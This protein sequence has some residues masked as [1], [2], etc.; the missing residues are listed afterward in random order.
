[1]AELVD[2]VLFL[3]ELETGRAVVG[4]G[5]VPVAPIVR[6]VVEAMT[7]ERR[8]ARAGARNARRRGRRR[9]RAA[10]DAPRADR[11]PL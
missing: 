5:D 7:A 10:A 3:S 2:D 4:L 1:M 8:A 9:R 6:D 11:E